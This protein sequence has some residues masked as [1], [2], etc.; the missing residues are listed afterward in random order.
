MKKINLV[1]RIVLI[2]MLVTVS[3]SVTAEEANR[4]DLKT[5]VNLVL[6]NDLDFI[7]AT[8]ELDKAELEY[9][10]RRA[11]NLLQPSRYSELETEFS[12][13]SARNGYQNAK[14]QLVADTITQYTNLWLAR[15]DLDIKDKN[16]GLENRLLKEA[17]AQYEI[18]DIGSVDLLE[19][20]NSY[21][22]TM[23]NLETARDD[24]QQGVRRFITRLNLDKTELLLADLIYTD[25]W[26]ITE[27][28]A[29]ETALE[30]SVDLDLKE[31]QLELAEIDLER[32]EVSAAELD[33][34]IKE[35]TV[36]AA[37]LEK[38]K[39][40]EELEDS[41]KEVYYQF[42]Q[43]VKRIGLTAERMAEAEEKYKLRQEQ[44]KAGLIT[45]SEVLE[46]EINMMRARYEYLSV[47]AE[48]YLKEEG[49]RQKMNL[50]SGVLTD[51]GSEDK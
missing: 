18:G 36:E 19:R 23:F 43:A 9:E 49:L 7:I 4:F 16:A 32:A 10:K 40:R 12:L 8:I 17:R 13:Q 14:Y 6:E 15:L 2:L 35:K 50:E 21:K 31:V 5:A 26:Q 22:D 34:K 29:V 51:E 42:K 11:N 37:R 39:A 44:Y 24:Y 20:E 27:T 38:E 45:I 1:N 48:Y 25:S 30:N 46:Y 41:T 33:K 3:W 47:I 28:E